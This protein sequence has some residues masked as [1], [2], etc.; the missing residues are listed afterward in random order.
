MHQW[1][2]LAAQVGSEAVPLIVGVCGV[3]G[4]VRNRVVRPNQGGL[5]D[6]TG[7]CPSAPPRKSATL[8]TL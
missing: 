8:R 6:V 3:C 2:F 7:V 5:L 4:E 1:T